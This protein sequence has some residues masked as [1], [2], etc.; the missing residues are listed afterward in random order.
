MFGVE[1]CATHQVAFTYYADQ[2]AVLVDDRQ[3]ADTVLEQQCRNLLHRCCGSNRDHID[4]HH[5][6]GVHEETPVR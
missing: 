6:A 4:R 3:C 5:I 1:L 2:R